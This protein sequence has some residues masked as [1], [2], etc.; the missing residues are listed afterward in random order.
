MFICILLF[1]GAMVAAV[2]SIPE[3]PQ[4]TYHQHYECPYG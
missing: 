4:H 2:V 3:P 1:A